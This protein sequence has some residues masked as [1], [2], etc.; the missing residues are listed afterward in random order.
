MADDENRT[1]AL[2]WIR[3][4]PEALCEH[5]EPWEHGT[6]YRTAR[7]P[8][9]SNLNVVCVTGGSDLDAGELSAFVA[10]SLAGLE[11]YRV[12]CEDADQAEPLRRDMEAL[13]FVSMRLAWLRFEGAPA[14]PGAGVAEVPYDEVEPLRAAWQ[15]EDYPGV[16]STEYLAQ[17]REVRLKLG[18]RTLAMYE[19]PRAVAFAGIEPGRDEFEVAALYVTPECR[20]R[21]RGTALALAAIAAGGPARDV[22]ICADDEDRPKELYER[23]GFAP[24][25]TTTRFMRLPGLRRPG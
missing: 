15:G 21:G 18:V 22:W 24:V 6:V 20:G 1:R 9:Y 13:G 4:E 14:E 16:D 10:R 23:L 8:R 2:A 5:I 11:A 19:G 17:A 25:L 7:Y 12:E 3:H